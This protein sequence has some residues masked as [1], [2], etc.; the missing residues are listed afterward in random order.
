MLEDA[1]VRK[2]F[3][4][5]EEQASFIDEEELLGVHR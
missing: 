3:L 5:G 2:D 4:G 1:D